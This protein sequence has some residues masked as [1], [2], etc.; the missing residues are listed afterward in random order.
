MWR[1]VA[2]DSDPA[3]KR[4]TKREK[5]EIKGVLALE[6]MYDAAI[7]YAVAHMRRI[8]GKLPALSNGTPSLDWKQTG[9]RKYNLKKSQPIFGWWCFYLLDKVVC[10]FLAKTYGA[11]WKVNSKKSL[12]RL[13][14]QKVLV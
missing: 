4:K 14:E 8:D 3:A 10:P 11:M 12:D 9:S 1:V 6:G 5:T 13:M 7:H 2:V